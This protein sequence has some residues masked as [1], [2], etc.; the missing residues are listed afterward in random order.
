LRVGKESGRPG[1]RA[2][3]DP[4]PDQDPAERVSR[5]RLLCAQCRLEITSD[6]A[7]IEVAGQH[8]HT[9]ANPHGFAFHIG[10]FA[11]APGCAG[12]GRA[13]TYWSWF[14]GYSWRLVLCRGC[15]AH[16]GW[17]FAAGGARFY[18]LI[19]DRLVRDPD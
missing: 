10:C 18:G 9:C 5:Q 4:D 3:Q 2:D 17:L 14:P 1:Q 11:S 12:V 15:H 19:L 16:L 13:E 7:R 8:E 6:E